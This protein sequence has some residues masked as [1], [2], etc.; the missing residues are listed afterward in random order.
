MIRIG[1]SGHRPNKLGGYNWDAPLNQRIRKNVEVQVVD[2]IN[3][4]PKETKFVFEFGGALGFD[5]FCFDVVFK[6]KELYAHTNPEIEITLELAIPFF[7]QYKVW[8][9]LEDVQRY[10]LQKKIAD[11]VTYVDK[12]GDYKVKG[13]TAGKYKFEKM[14]KRN[15]YIDNNVDILIAM[16]DGSDGG[17]KNCID[18]AKEIGLNIIRMYVPTKNGNQRVN[19]HFNLFK[20]E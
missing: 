10:L 14:Q 7:N 4:N 5:Q 1:F 13:A 11:I 17:T 8:T 19:R 15:E 12:L 3:Q 2:I 20:G 16:W 6:I 9:N 18:Y